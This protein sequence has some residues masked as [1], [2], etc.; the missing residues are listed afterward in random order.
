MKQN[1]SVPETTITFEKLEA[2]LSV[3]TGRTGDR[4]EQKLPEWARVG[5]MG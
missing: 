3:D 4:E 1:R 2:E 5:Q